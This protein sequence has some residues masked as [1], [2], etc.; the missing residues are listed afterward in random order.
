MLDQLLEKEKSWYGN[1]CTKANSYENIGKN[2]RMLTKDIKVYCVNYI[3]YCCD[4]EGFIKNY[5]SN[6]FKYKEL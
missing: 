6:S 4:Q 5:K 2:S 1:H 3:I